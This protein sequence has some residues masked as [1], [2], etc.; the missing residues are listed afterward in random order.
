MS[1]E[2]NLTG[3]SIQD[4]TPRSREHQIRQMRLDVGFSELMKEVESLVPSC[5]RRERAIKDLA[6][7]LTACKLAVVEN[8]PVLTDKPMQADKR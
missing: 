4:M 5:V 6:R 2:K 8:V 1:E 7:A 3:E